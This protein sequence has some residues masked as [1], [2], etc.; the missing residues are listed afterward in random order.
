MNK[1]IEVPARVRDLAG[2]LFSLQKADFS[3]QNVGADSEKTYVHLEES[4]E[5]DPSPVVLEW[6]EKPVPS[7][8][9]MMVRMVRFKEE[10]DI[11]RA[12]KEE[13]AKAALAEALAA[14]AAESALLAEPET[15]E[16]DVE[17]QPSFIKRIF[18]KL[19]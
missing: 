8:K 10:L 1:V 6:A 18:R 13:A 16:D 7:K 14:E 9:E 3:V 11:M 4:E 17:E 15:L 19:W 2:L 5:K 12:K